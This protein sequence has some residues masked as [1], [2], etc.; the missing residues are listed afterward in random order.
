MV[1]WV[2]PFRLNSISKEFKVKVKGRNVIRDGMKEQ[3]RDQ[4]RSPAVY[5]HHQSITFSKPSWSIGDSEMSWQLGATYFR[6]IN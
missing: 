3:N 4:G 5:Q 2:S 1:A 6:T